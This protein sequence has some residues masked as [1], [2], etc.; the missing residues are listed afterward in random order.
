MMLLMLLY[1]LVFAA[2]IIQMLYGKKTKIARNRMK[3]LQLFSIVL[4][5]SLSACMNV[6]A[7]N[8]FRTLATGTEVNM[9]NTIAMI[10][11]VILFVTNEIARTINCLNTRSIPT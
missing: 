4:S 3:T 7:A 2:I 10:I 1:C 11:F 5:A 9:V 8:N 6:N